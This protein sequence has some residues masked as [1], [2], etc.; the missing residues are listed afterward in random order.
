[1]N[2]VTPEQLI[3]QASMIRLIVPEAELQLDINMLPGTRNFSLEMIKTARKAHVNFINFY[4]YGNMHA[5]DFDKIR[6]AL[7]RVK[8]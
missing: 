2:P 3:Y 7:A 8:E 5:K 4:N 6:M 1:M